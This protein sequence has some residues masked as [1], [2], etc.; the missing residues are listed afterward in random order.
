MKN[1][2]GALGHLSHQDLPA[3]VGL[4]QAHGKQSVNVN[5]EWIRS[6]F[7]YSGTH[8]SITQELHGNLSQSS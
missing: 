6:V 8:L 3:W 1:Q 4:L 7:P 5:G 2:I